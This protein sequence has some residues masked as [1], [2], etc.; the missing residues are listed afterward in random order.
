MPSLMLLGANHRVAP[1][2]IRDKLA[3]SKTQLQPTLLQILAFPEVREV[4][5]LSTCNRT[6]I[7]T[8]AEGETV[9][10]RIRGFLC[11][12][13]GIDPSAV[14]SCLY[15]KMEEEAVLH[16]FSVAAGIDSMVLGEG[17]ILGQIKESFAAT[18]QVGSIGIHMDTLLRKALQTGKRAR[19]ETGIGSKAVSVSHAAVDLIQRTLGGCAHL[20]VMLIGAGDM[21]RLLAID[22]LEHGVESIF[23][24]NRT[25]AK[26]KALAATFKGVAVP[27][28]QFPSYLKEMDVVVTST[29]APQFILTRERL[30]PVLL[31]RDGRPLFLMDLAVPRDIDP[32]L[33]ELRGIRL[34]N[35]DDLQEEVVKTYEA[36]AKEVKRVRDILEEEARWFMSWRRTLP[37]IPAITALRQHAEM[38]R[39]KELRRK[40]T[41]LRGLSEGDRETV[42]ALTRAMLNK[43]LHTP[44]TRLKAAAKEGKAG[45]YVEAIKELFGI[46]S[47]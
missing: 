24:T 29:D 2:D 3:I 39:Q 33:G 25:P 46:G 17:Q 22:L 35:I 28:H 20:S 13:Q 11:Q 38:I 21:G 30:E 7:Y 15:E 32:A 26:A 44:T 31:Q 47:E 19:V 18:R 9:G 1:I 14:Q 6:E 42:N 8:V 37:V 23:F 10:Q 16:L 34:F 12:Q 36:K 40:A 4:F 45:P 27:F 43:L 5:L 41:K